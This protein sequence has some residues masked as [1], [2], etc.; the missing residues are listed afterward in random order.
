MLFNSLEFPL[1]L[2]LVLA[3]YFVV[4][5]R[6]WWR[7]RKAFLVAASYVFYASWNPFFSLLLLFSTVLD[8]TVARRM[9]RTE[10]RTARRLLLGVSLC[11]NLGLLGYFK[12]GNFFAQNAYR[13]LQPWHVLP[14]PVADIVLP[15]G[16]SFYTFQTLGYAIDVYRRQVPASRSPL[17]FA[18]FVSF[19]P[20]LVAGPIARAG[21]FLPQLLR[22]HDLTAVDVEF[23]VAR[24]AGG[25]VKKVV[26]ADTLAAYVD[27]IFLDPSLYRGANLLLAVYAY[28]FQIYFDFSGY[29]DIAIGVA[30]L[31]GLRL[32]ENFDRPYLAASPREF[33]R[34][35]HITLSTWLRDYL[36]ISLGGNRVERWRSS[37]NVMVTMLLGGLWHGAAWTFVAWGA[38]HGALLVVERLLPAGG[39][40]RGR[41]SERGA[42][43][44]TFHLVCLGW[45]LFRCASLG[46]AWMVLRGLWSS[47]FVPS[48]AAGQATVLVAVAF[49]LHVGPSASVL[50]ERFVRLPALWQGF[51]YAGVTVLVF[52]FSPATSRFIYFQF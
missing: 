47:E 13:L 11:G 36:Y 22:A 4:I 51:A 27:V 20:Q 52:L 45:I 2:G 3:G 34:R 8:Y 6:S 40:A 19:F 16:I 23:A 28:A 26:F 1:F 31:L 24:I 39:T 41:L 17:D 10:G 5:P 32:P 15:V 38:Y 43:V 30:R 21:S 50:R 42:R 9:E 25:F 49:A 29:S 46:D 33:W 44:V 14:P 37:V 48:L 7:A 35:W 12:Y 18:L